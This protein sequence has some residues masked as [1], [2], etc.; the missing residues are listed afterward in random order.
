M[1]LDPSE[2]PFLYGLNIVMTKHD[3]S[4]RRGAIVKALAVF[5]RHS[6]VEVVVVLNLVRKYK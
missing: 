1:T 5:T 6:N 3:S 2:D 4:V